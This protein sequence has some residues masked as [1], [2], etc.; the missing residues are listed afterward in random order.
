[1]PSF[2]KNINNLFKHDIIAFKYERD[3]NK[4]SKKIKN[5]KN[6]FKKKLIKIKIEYQDCV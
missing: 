1:M 6:I 4:T 3:Y 2:L 5:Y